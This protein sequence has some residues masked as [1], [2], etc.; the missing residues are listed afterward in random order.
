MALRFAE[1]VVEKAALEWLDGGRSRLSPGN[2][3]PGVFLGTVEIVGCRWDKPRE[4]YVYVLHAPKR[5]KR[6]LKAKSRPN[7]CFW[8]PKF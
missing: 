5:L 1:S 4:C 2:Y 7:P 6:R 8:R 3:P